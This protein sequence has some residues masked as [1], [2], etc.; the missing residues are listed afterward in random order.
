M[1]LRDAVRAWLL[2]PE[3]SATTTP[4]ELNT[5]RPKAGTP[6]AVTSGWKQWADGETVYRDEFQG[7]LQN[8]VIMR[9]A[10][11]AARDAAIPVGSRVDGMQSWTTDTRT[12]WEWSATRAAWM[13]VGTRG[14]LAPASATTSTA[15]TTTSVQWLSTSPVI[16]PTAGR[17]YR[18]SYCGRVG[19]AVANDVVALRLLA[20][21]GTQLQESQARLTAAGTAGYTTLNGFWQGTLPATPTTMYL[22]LV[23]VSGTGPATGV[24]ST[25]LPAHMLWED[26]GT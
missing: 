24:A 6:R 25:T 19:S 11:P 12:M 21:G 13:S 16:P 7:L 23:L 15:G 4:H 5:P 14:V 8:Q 1:T 22:F 17:R 18:V 9:F 26:I 10:T 3:P 20:E 2:E